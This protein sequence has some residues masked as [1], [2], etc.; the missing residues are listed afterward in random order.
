LRR[1]GERG[2]L[3]L[4]AVREPLVQGQTVAVDLLTGGIARIRVGRFVPGLADT[5]RRRLEGLRGGGLRGIALDL[6][7]VVSGELADGVALADLFLGP[8]QRLASSHGRNDQVTVAFKDSTASPFDSLPIA[9]LV[10][11]GTA[12]AAEV[13]AGALQDHDRAAVLGGV[14]FGRGVTRSTFPLGDGA[15]L[16]LTTALWFPPSG[17]EIQRPPLPADGDSVARP[18]L[19]T[20]GGRTVLG[21]GG[22]IPDRLVADSGPVDVVL[23]DARALLIRAGSARGVLAQLVGR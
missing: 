9:V 2:P 13:T 19:K 17:R 22:I 11:G 7:D 20:D 10:N 3:E 18:K 1:S 5:V 8:G 21:G 4:V 14:T 12:G 16:R 23:A 15:S 6:R